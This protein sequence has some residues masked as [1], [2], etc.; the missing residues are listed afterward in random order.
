[1]TETIQEVQDAFEKE[2][3]KASKVSVLYQFAL[4]LV[5][6]MMVLL[7]LIYVGIVG[8]VGWGV[9]Y[10]ATE[11]LTLFEDTGGR[12][13]VFAYVTPLVVGV[14]CFF[15]L[16]KPLLARKP[17]TGAR[18]VLRP[19]EEPGL[20]LFVEKICRAVGASEPREIELNAEVNAAAAFRR[21][22]LSLF[23]KDL[24]LVIGLPLVAGMNMRSF[25]GVLAHE[26]GHFAQGLGMRLTYIVRSVNAWFA[27]VVY[28]RD[29]WDM[30]LEEAAESWDGWISIIL[31]IARFFVW[32]SRR[33][34]WCLMHVGHAISCF[35]LRQMEY[36]ADSYEVQFAGSETFAKT[37]HCLLYT[38]P[39]P[40]D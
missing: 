3:L 8:L 32:L 16:T 12:A 31:Q 22:W 28:E 14:I 21:G 11:N 38:S 9:Y 27:R 37:S 20:E 19:G 24:N 6:L 17:Q 18:F 26:F 40:R 39:S 13:A 36:D 7:P 35:A 4:S 30:K 15:F 33:I 1:M 25:G 29:S 5:A 2:K 34:L 23:G 10:H